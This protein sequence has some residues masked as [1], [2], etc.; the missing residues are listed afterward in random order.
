MASNGDNATCIWVCVS[1]LLCHRLL[2]NRGLVLRASAMSDDALVGCFVGFTS[3]IWL[4]VV[5]FLG[6]DSSPVGQHSGIV[7]LTRIVSSLANVPVLPLAVFLF[8][9][10]SKPGTRA[11]GTNTAVDHVT[12]SPAFLACCSIAT[13]IPSLASLAIGDYTTPILNTA[14]FLLFA[15]QGVPRHPYDSARHR[16]SEDYLRIALATDHH[17]GTVYIL[18]STLGGMDAVWS[19]KISNEHIAVDR[20]IMTLFRHMRSDRWHVG[21]P[22]ERLRQTLAAYHERVMLSAEGA[23]FLASWIYLADSQ[24]RPA[25]A[26]RMSMIRCERAPGVHLIGRDLMYA[27]CHAEYL[28]FMS[29]GRLAPGYKEKLGMLRLMSRSGAAKGGTISDKTI[30][31][32][33]GFDGYAEAVRH[34][35][36]MFGY[37]TEQ[38]DA[39]E[40]LDFTGTHPPAF[41]FA[42][43]KAP[44]SI[45]EYVTELWDLSTRNTESTF[46]ALYFFTTVWFMEL[47]NVGGFHIFPLRCR[48]R[49]GDAA[50]RLLAWRQVW[51]AACV[52]QLVSVSPALLG[53]FVFG[54]GA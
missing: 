38:N 47:G 36:A 45:D 50:T 32:R 20:E 35:Y 39:A 10:S 1:W 19:P 23:S 22:L 3:S 9:V 24:E 6:G 54:L 11:S 28:V 34:V 7:H 44:A 52:A 17:E 21:E 25:A 43:K 5:L 29:Q 26:E 8:W 49:D 15:L 30:G 18:P 13:L 42:L 31:F 16:Y 53:W 40:A 51:Y 46:S 33:P 2:V 37:N 48:S 27:L 14:G 12:S 41:S 4:V